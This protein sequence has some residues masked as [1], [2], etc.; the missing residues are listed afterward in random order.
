VA[1]DFR[2]HIHAGDEVQPIYDRL[3]DIEDHEGGRIA[4]SHD[5]GDVFVYAST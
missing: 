3:L 2:I 4:V 5:G 1:D